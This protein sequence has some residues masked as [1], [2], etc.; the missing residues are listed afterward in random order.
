MKIYVYKGVICF[1]GIKYFD[2]QVYIFLSLDQR[3][4][5]FF[6]GKWIN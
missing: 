2:S 3:I 4:R 1:F 5:R 6:F